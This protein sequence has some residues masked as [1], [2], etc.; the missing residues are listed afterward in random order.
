MFKFKIILFLFF[1]GCTF[2]A[3]TKTNYSIYKQIYSVNSDAT[4]FKKEIIAKGA[5][6]DKNYSAFVYFGELEKVESIIAY[7][8]NS[9]KRKK[10]N[11]NNIYK[12]DLLSENFYDGYKAY[13]IDF[14]N[15]NKI[16]TNQLFEF[17]TSILNSEIFCISSLSFYQSEKYKIDTAENIVK[18]PIGYYLYIN[19]EDLKKAEN[20]SVDSICSSTEK[21][22]TFRK[23]FKQKA[24]ISPEKEFEYYS[25]R[26]LVC[27][28][29]ANPLLYFNNWYQNLLGTIPSSNTYKITCDSLAKS[30]S[31]KDSLIKHVFEYVTKKIRYIDIENGINAFRPRPSDEVLYKQ[32]G[33]CKDMAL[34]LKNMY[35]FLGFDAFM[36]LSSTLS[37]DHQFDFPTLSSANHAICILNYNNKLYYLDATER[38]GKYNQPSQQIQETKA[39]ISKPGYAKIIDIPKMDGNFNTTTSTFILKIEQ[40]K[41]KGTFEN[42][43]KGYSKIFIENITENYSTSK[44]KQ[45]LKKYFQESNYNISFE[46]IEYLKKNESI[47]ITGEV[48]LN[49]SVFTKVDNKT[50][51]NF[52]F[53]PFIHTLNREIDSTENYPIY[54][55]T[56]NKNKLIIE[57]PFNINRIESLYSNFKHTENNII[58]SFNITHHQNK[59]II[60]YKYENPYVI[61]TK[62][63]IPSFNKINQFISKTLNHEIIIY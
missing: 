56:N 22:Y 19:L 63:I 7:Y 41:I 24:P 61:L 35:T 14:I 57:F 26:V 46:N 38:L 5:F 9:N 42:E 36:A 25:V 49:P 29:K 21:T 58:Y 4:S 3:Y 45:L 15:E 20:I 13:K 51:F 44:S 53:S 6:T 1:F 2:R 62:D 59:L 37:N 52:N 28:E 10:I 55:T 11:K 32:Q 23:I 8:I 50:F 48:D 60:E 54:R 47:N 43:Y 31:N 27:P 33:D 17:K 34:L 39:M 18:V 12:S 40:N 30:H 16:N